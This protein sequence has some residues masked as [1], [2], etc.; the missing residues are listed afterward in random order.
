M[1]ETLEAPGA[2]MAPPPPLVPPPPSPP[3]PVRPALCT[4]GVLGL[5]L[6]LTGCGPGPTTVSLAPLAHRTAPVRDLQPVDDAARR[7]V[8][9]LGVPG[10]AVALIDDGRPLWVSVHGVANTVTGAPVTA[11]T[12]FMLASVSK[13]VV[14]TALAQAQVR[15]ALDLDAPLD[16]LTGL[17]IENPRVADGAFT[18]RHLAT[19]TAGVRDNWEVL[20]GTYVLG[21]APIS[22]DT[23]VRR[24]FLPG[25]DWYDAEANFRAAAP[26][27]DRR[28]SNLGTALAGWALGAAT[29]VR[30]DDWSDAE[31][32]GPVGMETAGWHLA[33]HDPA[34]LAMPHGDDGHGGHFPYGHYGYPDW[35]DGQLRASATDMARFVAAVARP[36]G[37][38]DPATRALLVAVPYP[39]ASENQGLFWVRRQ[40]GGRP[41]WS[42]SGDDAGVTTE[43]LF[44]PESGDGVVVLM[45]VDGTEERIQAMRA[46]EALALE[47]LAA[48]SESR[49]ASD[50]PS[51]SG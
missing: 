24:Y 34:S 30:L 35:P 17:P 44:D 22:L 15:G 32:F 36:G 21:D 10:V 47:A 40:R 14:G 51:R 13:T 11:D 33:D 20:A 41:T 45:N 23:L 29:G 19:H 49:T 8:E 42:H 7:L 5:A 4:A 9:E 27:T 25:G 43:L 46:L 37:G 38:L 39:A 6:G 2:Q 26:G 48:P 50:A 31:I 28:Y 12:P 18:L 3:P 1:Q 16:A